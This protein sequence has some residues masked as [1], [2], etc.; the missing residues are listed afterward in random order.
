MTNPFV[1]MELHPNSSDKAKSFY[2]DLL[3]W[4]FAEMDMGGAAY[5]MVN[6]GA[7]PFAGIAPANG[8]SPHW[9]PYLGVADLDASTK[10]A[11]QL[12]AKVVQ[13]RVDIPAGSFVFI[14]DP[15]G[16]TVALFQPK[17]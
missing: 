4:K 3:G 12:G 11:E 6:N 9:L 7:E 13:P 5:T 15:A 8:G 14:E 17:R 16:A 2:G 10:K 1:Y